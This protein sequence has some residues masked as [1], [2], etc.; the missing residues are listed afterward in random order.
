LYIVL[1]ITYE[2]QFILILYSS[3]CLWCLA[4]QYW[5]GITLYP[6]IYLNLYF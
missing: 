6:R 1:N 5:H 4:L 3:T 2:R